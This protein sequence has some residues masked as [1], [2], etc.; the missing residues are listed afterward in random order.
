MDN[1]SSEM[2][3]N[4]ANPSIIWTQYMDFL[5]EYGK[6]MKSI[7]TKRMRAN[8]PITWNDLDVI[9]KQIHDKLDYKMTWDE[10]FNQTGVTESIHKKHKVVRLSEAELRNIIKKTINEFKCTSYWDNGKDESFFFPPDSVAFP[11]STIRHGDFD[12]GLE[13]II[14]SCNHH[15]YA[16]KY[17]GGNRSMED[18]IKRAAINRLAIV[19]K[20]SLLH[21]KEEGII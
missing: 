8:K 2:I 3:V 20:E 5:S 17:Y 4:G 1:K 14:S 10:K 19:D 11:C 7:Y 18:H 6:Y 15:Y 21:M 9:N 16:N 13:A 12:D